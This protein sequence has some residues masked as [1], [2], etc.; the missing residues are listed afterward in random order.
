[1]ISQS[2]LLNAFL[3]SISTFSLVMPN[4]QL[5]TPVSGAFSDLIIKDLHDN[6]IINSNK[7]S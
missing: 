4:N 1:M 5:N 2:K 3:R 6:L 7:R